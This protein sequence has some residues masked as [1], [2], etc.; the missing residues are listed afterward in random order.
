MYAGDVD[1]SMSLPDSNARMQPEMSLSSRSDPA[2]I[3]LTTDCTNSFFFRSLKSSP[4]VGFLTNIVYFFV[5]DS[6][7]YARSA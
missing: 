2:L 4:S 7:D 5:S 3:P 6:H 1:R